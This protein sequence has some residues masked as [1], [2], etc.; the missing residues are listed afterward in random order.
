MK[1]EKRLKEVGALRVNTIIK[2]YA[3]ILLAEGEK[4]GYELMR[5]LEKMTGMP[6]GPSQIYPYLKKLEEAGLVES[7]EIGSRD[8]K[9][10]RLTPEGIEFVR[11]VLE[12]SLTVIQTAVKVLGRDKICLP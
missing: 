3:L 12:R 6:I 4:H 11:D 10:Y 8:K 5:T 1:D 7:R 9:S 2:L